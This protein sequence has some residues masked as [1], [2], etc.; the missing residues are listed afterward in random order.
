MALQGRWHSHLQLIPHTAP[1]PLVA[2]VIVAVRRRSN[3]EIA[4]SECRQVVVRVHEHTKLGMHTPHR[5]QR[6]VVAICVIGTV[7]VSVCA[8]ARVCVSDCLCGAT[9]KLSGRRV[10]KA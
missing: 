4:R 2:G 7:C 9:G 5:T 10:Q 8:R 3:E 1:I 6:C